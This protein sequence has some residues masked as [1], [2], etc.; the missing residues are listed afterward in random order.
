MGE[1][2]GDGLRQL[3]VEER[4]EMGGIGGGE[5]VEGR[6]HRGRADP[7]EHGR[8]PLGAERRL[9]QARGDVASAARRREVPGG[10]AM[11]LPECLHRRLRVEI[12]QS[13]DLGGD[14][15][16]LRF[17][18]V[19]HDLDGLCAVEVHQDDRGRLPI[20]QS[21]HTRDLSSMRVRSSSAVR[22]GS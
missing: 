9:Q 18:E 21:A 5:E 15:L 4:G 13:D 3:A 17:G 11:E 14:G 2:E 8:R 7:A 16:G 10:D 6:A 12:L 22:C 1:H 20:G 19:L